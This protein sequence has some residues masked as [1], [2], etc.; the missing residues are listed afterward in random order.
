MATKTTT[1]AFLLWVTL[2]AFTSAVRA[3]SFT[4]LQTLERVMA[5][6]P[7]L[8]VAQMQVDRAWQEK[9]K[10]ESRIGWGLGAQA[11]YNHD[12]AP[13]GAA[14]SDTS[15]L[16]LSLDRPLASG[17]SL[18]L[19]GTYTDSRYTP[20]LFGSSYSRTSRVDLNY[21]KP[22]GRGAGNPAYGQ[23][24]VSAEAGARIAEANALAT[25]DQIAR[26]T[27]DLFYGA[28]LTQARIANAR[29]GI[30]RAERLKG[31]IGSNTQLG[32]AER[33]DLLQTEAQLQSQRADH[34]V[35]MAAWAQQRASLNRLMGRP[36]DAN[37]EPVLSPLPALPELVMDTLVTEAEQ[38]SADIRRN[39]ARLAIAEAQLVNSRDSAKSTVDLVLGAGYGNLQAGGMPPV[40]QTDTAYSARIEF[41][42]ALD[43]RGNQ[44]VVTQA[45][46]DR[47]IALRDRQ[48][49]KDDLQYN[50]NGLLRDIEASHTALETQRLR[51]ETEDAKV[52]EANKLYRQGRMDTARLIQFENERTFA[53]LALKQQQLELARKHYTLELL[54][55]Q[56]WQSANTPDGNK[57]N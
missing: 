31:Y 32:L 42:R 50:L 18:G 51:V 48:T 11:G 14:I 53:N 10:V 20:S 40:D 24:L 35:L 52:A 55:G 28:V 27:M 6:Y 19:S 4:Y 5:T 37:I 13:F 57:K 38:A 3:E 15:N 54:R 21:R 8:E 39:E 22:L 45:Q 49:L 46:I 26:Q 7:S 33:Q 34:D 43:Q 12:L 29:V 56:L 17:G 25:R 1:L 47:S 16:G 36:A 9:Q 41:R 30:E 23:G 2:T 44:A